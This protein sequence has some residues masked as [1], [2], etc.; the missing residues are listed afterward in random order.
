MW[1]QRLTTREPD[2]LQIEVAI[3]AMDKVLELEEDLHD[4][5]AP[6]MVATDDRA[7]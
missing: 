5:R 3:A 6:I 4:L 1:F 7:T 2:S